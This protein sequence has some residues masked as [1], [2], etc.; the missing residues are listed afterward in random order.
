MSSETRPAGLALLAVARRRDRAAAPLLA[1]RAEL[2]RTRRS[3]LSSEAS[4]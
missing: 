4:P 3:L 2:D 1:T